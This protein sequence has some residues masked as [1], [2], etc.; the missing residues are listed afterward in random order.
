MSE[1]KLELNGIIDRWE[2]QM[3]LYGKIHGEQAKI[4]ADDPNNDFNEDLRHVYYDG[5][6]AF[7]QIAEYTGDSSWYIFAER[8]GS[9]NEAYIQAS[10]GGTQGFRAF[11][12][13]LVDRYERTGDV[14]AKDA[15][16]LMAQN[17]GWTRSGAPDSYS[18][19]AAFSREVAYG[20]Q[21]LVNAEKVGFSNTERLEELV[22]FS[23]GHLD[24]WFGAKTAP[25]IQPFMVGLTAYALIEYSDATDHRDQQIVTE[26]THALDTLWEL[27]WDAEKQQF[28]YFYG[29]F[30]DPEGGNIP[31]T[32]DL[33]LL[34]APAYEW[35]YQETGE[36]RFRTRGEDI[37]TGG[38][39]GAW[40]GGSKQFNQNYRWSFDYVELYTSSVPEPPFDAAAYLASHPDLIRAFGYD[41]GAASQHYEQYGRGEGRTITFQADDYLA[42]YGD[43]IQAFGYDLGAATQHYIQH[44]FWE[45]RSTTFNAAS[46]V[47]SYD[48]LINT[49]GVNL[50]AATEY[51]IKGGFQSGQRITFQADNYLASYGDLIEAFGYNLDAA[52][53]HYIQYGSSEGRVRDG[54][55]EVAYLN[56]YGDLQAAFGGNYDLATRHYID[57]GYFEGRVA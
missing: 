41:L 51:Y 34:I 22:D 14:G 18:E 36:E 6:F 37:F 56:N 42:S 2:D 16:V 57:Y 53:M 11:S 9:I 35:V 5:E 43:L 44:G 25:Y 55:N 3:L 52:A 45:G 31:D 15:L 26:L 30:P 17:G 29:D 33:N 38:V 4:Y 46:Y 8:A 32:T 19:D 24:Q 54:F 20:I 28:D 7:A 50:D 48:S 49:F 21:T 39:T 12:H 10:S 23:F 27:T 47:A 1:L 13:G 40:L